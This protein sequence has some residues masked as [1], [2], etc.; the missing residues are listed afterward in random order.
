MAEITGLF[1]KKG[2][3]ETVF[4]TINTNLEWKKLF[5]M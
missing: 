3:V 4:Y 2:F 1:D 5:V